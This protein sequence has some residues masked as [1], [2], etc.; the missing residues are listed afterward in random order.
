MHCSEGIRQGLDQI[1]NYRKRDGCFYVCDGAN[2]AADYLRKEVVRYKH[3][4]MKTCFFALLVFLST[5]FQSALAA[6]QDEEARFAS[7][8]RKAFD[9]HDTDALSALTCLERVSNKIK[10]S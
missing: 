2:K 6:T 8:T 5:F 9:T 3:T 4:T 10:K 1:N 7:A